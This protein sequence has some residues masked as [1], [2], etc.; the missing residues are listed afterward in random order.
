MAELDVVIDF[1]KPSPELI[2]AISAEGER[3]EKEAIKKELGL[4]EDIDIGFGLGISQLSAE[5]MPLCQ[6]FC[7]E[8][9]EGYLIELAE[10]GWHQFNP[11]S[12]VEDF[13][14]QTFWGGEN[15]L[16][17]PEAQKNAITKWN[18]EFLKWL[19]EEQNG[20]YQTG[21]GE[22]KLENDQLVLT[23]YPEPPEDP[24]IKPAEFFIKIYPSQKK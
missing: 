2:E 4:K 12:A 5:E 13:L 9:F 23:H 19:K 17:P 1:F 3:S 22:I 24:D 14:I 10:R 18:E 6:Q 15:S 8:E 11:L 21:W 16:D 7:S 20:F